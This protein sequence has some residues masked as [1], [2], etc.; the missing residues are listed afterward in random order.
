MTLRGLGLLLPAAVIE[1]STAVACNSTRKRQLD[2]E[3][4][5]AIVSVVPKASAT[6]VHDEHEEETEHPAQPRPPVPTATSLSDDAR[7]SVSV[8]RIFAHSGAVII[9]KSDAGWSIAGPQGCQVSPGRIER[10]LNN[11]SSL[12]AVP[13]DEH[14]ADGSDFDLQIVAQSGEERVLHFDIAGRRDGKDLI[15]LLDRSTFRVSGLDRELLSAE[16]LVWCSAEK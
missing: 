3:H 2:A 8:L 6:G 12:T 14:P 16:P 13:S 9:R 10:A 11:L 7:H 1:L 4:A 5:P 15:Q